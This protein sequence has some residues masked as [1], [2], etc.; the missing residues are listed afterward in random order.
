NTYVPFS[1][2]VGGAVIAA[3]LFEV[4]RL[5][6]GSYIKHFSSYV[7]VYGTL[8]T[9]PLFLMWLYI[10]WNIILFG[11]EV[12]CSIAFRASLRY[13]EKLTPFQHCLRWLHH[14]YVAQ[15]DGHLLNI[16]D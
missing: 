15:Q 1:A 12:S 16:C 14:M 5:G 9:I 13:G 4:A 3:F 8:A 10:S 7:F 11:A 6:F 2:G